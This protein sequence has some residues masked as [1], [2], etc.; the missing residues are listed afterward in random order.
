MERY[1]GFESEVALLEGEGLGVHLWCDFT[2][3]SCGR[4]ICGK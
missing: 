4:Q 1:V 3:K 2:V